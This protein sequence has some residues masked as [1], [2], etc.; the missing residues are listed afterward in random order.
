[1][2]GYEAELEPPTGAVESYEAA[3]AVAVA[4]LVRLHQLAPVTLGAVGGCQAT[5]GV[6]IEAAERVGGRDRC[7][8][9]APQFGELTH[10]WGC[11]Q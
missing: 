8:D 5:V 6:V 11:S 2:S 4:A 10:A 1:V 3:W 9:R 7:A